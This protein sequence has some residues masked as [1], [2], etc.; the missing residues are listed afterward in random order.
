[1]IA[2]LPFESWLLLFLA[3]GI[4]LAIEIPFFVSQRRARRQR[5]EL[6]DGEPR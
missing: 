1:M 4:G 3:V 2:G 6:S 5:F